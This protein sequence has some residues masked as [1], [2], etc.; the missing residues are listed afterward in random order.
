MT[1]LIIVSHSKESNDDGKPEEVVGDDGA[2]SGGVLPAEDGVENPPSASS[3]DIG[4]TALYRIRHGTIS[5]TAK[6]DF[7]E[8]SR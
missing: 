2:V 5:S 4:V 1:M 7:V 8:Y 3:V 6:I